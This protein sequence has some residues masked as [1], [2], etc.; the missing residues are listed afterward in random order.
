MVQGG[1]GGR[2]GEWESGRHN[3]AIREKLDLSGEWRFRIDSLGQ[4]IKNPMVF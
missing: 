4:G 3:V 2:V 1:K